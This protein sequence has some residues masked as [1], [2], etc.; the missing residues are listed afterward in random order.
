ME[1]PYIVCDEDHRYGLGDLARVVIGFLSLQNANTKGDH[2]YD[3]ELGATRFAA[4][5]R[6]VP[7]HWHICI[8]EPMMVWWKLRGVFGPERVRLEK[9]S[10]IIVDQSVIWQDGAQVAWALAIPSFDFVRQKGGFSEREPVQ[11]FGDLGRHRFA[12]E[13]LIGNGANHFVTLWPES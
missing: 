4:G 6:C 3:V 7:N 9:R 1:I 12:T 2:L 11:Q 8:V 13:A 5:I 10:Q